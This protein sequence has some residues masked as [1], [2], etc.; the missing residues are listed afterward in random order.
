MAKKTLLTRDAIMEARDIPEEIVPVPEWGGSVR[1]VGM[2]AKERGEYE[3]AFMMEVKGRRGE[4]ELKRNRAAI[5]QVRER[6]VVHTVVDENGN[7]L[8]TDED[9]AALSKKSAAAMERIVTVAQR[10]SG[11]TESD[12]EELEKNFATT[13]AEDSASVSPSP[14]DEQ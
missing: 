13:D 8:F 12:I 7:R 4:P 5:K 1:V 9:V 3:S 14:S 6:L 11:L 10:L 2:T